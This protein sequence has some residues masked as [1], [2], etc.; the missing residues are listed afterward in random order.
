M[1]DDY[2]FDVL[3]TKVQDNNNDDNEDNQISAKSSDLLHCLK[4]VS[5]VS[6]ATWEQ[7]REFQAAYGKKV[8]RGQTVIY[9]EAGIEAKLH[10]IRMGGEAFYPVSWIEHLSITATGPTLEES[11]G[12]EKEDEFARESAFVQQALDAASKGYEHLEELGVPY[13][14]PDDYYAES[15]KSDLHMAKIRRNLLQQQ[16][17]IEIVEERRKRREQKK[18]GKQI[19]LEKQQSRDKQKKNELAAVKKWRQQ[20]KSDTSLTDDQFF[21]SLEQNNGQMPNPKKRQE[22]SKPLTYK[23]QQALKKPNPKRQRRNEKFGFGGQKRGS[24]S[25]SRDST[26][27]YSSFSSKKNRSVPGDLKNKMHKKRSFNK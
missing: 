7:L 11:L 5:S 21:V 6:S 10:E 19:Q 27:D 12:E 3:T 16:K 18:Y 25:N 23:Q 14:R 9:S 17:K 13:L 22:P 4:D 20:G 24:K 2:D 8:K 26:N 15:L 1:S